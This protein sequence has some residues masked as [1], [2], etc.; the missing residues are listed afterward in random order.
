MQKKK[1]RTEKKK[2]GRALYVRR[3]NVKQCAFKSITINLQPLLALFI[4]QQT[5]ASATNR[6]AG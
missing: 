1:Y 2:P 3:K 4:V 5:Q 6:P